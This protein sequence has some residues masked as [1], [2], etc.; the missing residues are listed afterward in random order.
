MKHWY[1]K[2]SARIGLVAKKSILIEMECRR[3]QL[4]L[5]QNFVML[6]LDAELEKRDGHIDILLKESETLWMLILTGT[7]AEIEGDE[8]I[9]VLFSSC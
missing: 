1:A 2:I 4:N 7:C 6:L 5:N 3:K 9:Q 8:Q